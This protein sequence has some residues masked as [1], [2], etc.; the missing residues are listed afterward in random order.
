MLHGSS[1]STRTHVKQGKS[2][3]T[4]AG[5]VHTAGAQTSTEDV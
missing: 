1:L 4:Q 5:E 2:P 3:E